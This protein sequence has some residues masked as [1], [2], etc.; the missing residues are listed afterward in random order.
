M[1][2]IIAW[3]KYRSSTTV[4]MKSD[5][6]TGDEP[7]RAT[8]NIRQSDAPMVSLTPCGPCGQ[9]CPRPLVSALKKRERRIFFVILTSRLFFCADPFLEDRGEPGRKFFHKRSIPGGSICIR[10]Q[11]ILE[12]GRGTRSADGIFATRACR[13]RFR[14]PFVSSQIGRKI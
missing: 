4:F 12:G 2:V 3:R 5:A 6:A 9:F 14:T 10:E 13:R 1:Q 8:G 11:Q 7:K